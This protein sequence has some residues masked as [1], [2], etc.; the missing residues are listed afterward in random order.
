MAEN[1]VAVVERTAAKKGSGELARAYLQHLYSEEGQE[2]AA[3]HS[4]RPRS[5]AVLKKYAAVFKPIQLF[6]VQDM[7]GSLSEAQKVHFNDGGQFD[8]IYTV[9]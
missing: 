1:P 3:R 6:T 8:K 5:A 9:R 7:F 2:I 4:I